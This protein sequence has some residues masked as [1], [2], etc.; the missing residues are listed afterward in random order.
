[1]KKTIMI[2]TSILTTLLF[3]NSGCF[4]GYGSQTVNV[5]KEL[6]HP[7]AQIENTSTLTVLPVECSE[8][9]NAQNSCQQAPI[10][11]QEITTNIATVPQGEETYTLKSIQGKSITIS[12][13]KNGFEFPQFPNK[14]VILQM[15]GKNCPHCINEIP[16]MNKLYRKY[17]GNLE[18]IALQVEERM[19]RR[20]AQSLIQRHHIQYPIIPG[21]A[22]KNLQFTV[23][24][25]YGWSG[26]L[27]YTLV[28]KDGITEFSY[29]GEVSY[30][31][32]NRDISSLF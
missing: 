24:L 12:E 10:E 8:D 21:D 11:R 3:L 31:E 20:E 14:V 19:S 7:L 17:R 26:I 27:P 29:P 5:Q 23:Q 1:M 32:I 18:I 28:I 16:I 2:Q 30:K 25:T 4:W 22:A 6:T 15:F 13:K 9:I